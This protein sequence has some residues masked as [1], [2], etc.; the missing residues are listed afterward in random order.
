MLFYLLLL[1]LF[2]VFIL[3]T[4][5]IEK[6]RDEKVR[7]ITSRAIEIFI[8]ALAVGLYCYFYWGSPVPD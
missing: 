2:R 5:F 4:V 3:E 8:L 1:T 6:I 7:K